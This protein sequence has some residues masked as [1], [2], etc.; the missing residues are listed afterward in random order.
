MLCRYQAGQN[1]VFHYIE[2]FYNSKRIYQTLNYQTP[3]E[4]EEQHQTKLAV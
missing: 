4:F 2:T 3:D 1:S